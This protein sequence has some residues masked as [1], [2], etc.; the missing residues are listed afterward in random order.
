M[1]DVQPESQVRTA[2]RPGGSTGRGFYRH[3][4]FCPGGKEHGWLALSAQART[5]FTQGSKLFSVLAPAGSTGAH[6][7][8]AGGQDEERYARGGTALQ[9]QDGGQGGEHGDLFCAGQQLR[10]VSAD[11]GL[12]TETSR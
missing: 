12:G 2:H 5:G 10:G 4:P 11:G 6:V 1:R 9:S 3:R 7:V 8:S